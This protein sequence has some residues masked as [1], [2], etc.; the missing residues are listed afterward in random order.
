MI[1]PKINAATK[2]QDYVPHYILYNAYSS[3]FE[4]PIQ[5]IATCK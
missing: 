4:I 5:D 2:L 3:A 1:E